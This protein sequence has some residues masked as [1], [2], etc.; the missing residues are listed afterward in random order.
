MTLQDLLLKYEFDALVPDLLLTDKPAK[1]NLYAF[2]EAFDELRRMEPGDP[3]GEK[4]VVGIEVDTDD[5][6]NE[7]ERY[8]D[9]SNCE[10]DF[11]EACLAKEVTIEAKVTE[12]HTLAWILWHMTFYGFNTEEKTMWDDALHN[13]Y[14]RKAALL[15]YRQHCNYARI[16][17]KKCPTEDDL[18]CALSLDGWKIYEK[19]EAHRNR[20]K[21]MRD[22]RQNRSIARLER[23]GKITRLIDRLLLH[24]LDLDY[25]EVKYL[26]ET[27]TITLFDFFSR[28]PTPEGRIDYI[29]ENMK[30]HFNSERLQDY[31]RFFFI[32][33]YPENYPFNPDEI[34]PLAE[35]LQSITSFAGTRD[36]IHL[37]HSPWPSYD[38]HLQIVCSR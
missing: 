16:K 13:K 11:W 23:Q 6:D 24:A 33:E 15:K 20:A 10:D 8:M 25:A 30:A 19:R 17:C 21:R 31:T 5:D 1:D 37:G 29:L 35:Y 18:R 3:H 32:V 22:A 38:L 14:E 34:N 2:K 12:A 26:E 28:T 7:I 4:I 27:N 36:R 9:A